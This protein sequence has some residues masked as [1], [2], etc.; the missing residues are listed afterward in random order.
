[1]ESVEQ[2]DLWH[3]DSGS[4]A[5]GVI[6]GSRAGPR[7]TLALEAPEPGLSLDATGGD[8]FDALQQLRLQLEP[9]GWY[10][11]CNG[12]RVDCYTSG[13]G[14]DMG[15]GRAVYVLSQTL[16]KLPVVQTFEPTEPDKIGT[17]AEQNAN[18]QLWLAWRRTQRP[19]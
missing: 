4:V 18:F 1:M 15:V 7:I 13:M 11:L 9:L 14:R 16:D 6:V 5:G 3:K 2:V 8:F 10:P 17:V 12:A 19:A